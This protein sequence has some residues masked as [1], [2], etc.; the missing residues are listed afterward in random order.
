MHLRQVPY[1]ICTMVLE[2]LLHLPQ[3]LSHSCKIM[4]ISKY[5]PMDAMGYQLV[6]SFL[7][8]C[9]VFLFFLPSLT[10]PDSTPF[11]SCASSIS[12]H[13][14]LFTTF[15]AEVAVALVVDVSG[16]VKGITWIKRG[17]RWMFSAKK[18]GTIG[19]PW[20]LVS[21]LHRLKPNLLTSY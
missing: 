10:A 9:F 13:S 3:H 17:P 6:N 16:Y 5:C 21:P 19:C 4:Y 11:P 8:I 14:A 20:H 12:N 1:A 15:T 2:Y 7:R 18:Q